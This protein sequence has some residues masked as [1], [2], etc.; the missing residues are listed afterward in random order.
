ML[1]IRL[2][3]VGVGLP[4]RYNPLVYQGIHCDNSTQA[5]LRL[6]RFDE[7]FGLCTWDGN[8]PVV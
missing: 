1:G 6:A 2:M 8:A 7:L 3:D 4:G 5:C